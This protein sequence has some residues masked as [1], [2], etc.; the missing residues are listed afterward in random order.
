MSN[1]TALF[2][3]ERIPDTQILFSFT[4]QFIPDIIA[5]SNETNNSEQICAQ[6]ATKIKIYG[7]AQNEDGFK[8]KLLNT[9]EIFDKIEYSDKFHSLKKKDNINSIILSLSS[10]KICFIE[11]NMSYDTFE[12]LALYSVDKFFLGGKINIEQSFRICSSLSFGYIIFLF[13]ENKMSILRKKKDKKKKNL[14]V[15][16]SSKKEK[17]YSD[18]INGDKFFR[19][20]IYLN[21]LNIKYNIY[22]IINIYIPNKNFEL[23][24]FKNPDKKNKEGKIEIVQLYI[25]YVESKFDNND[26]INTNTTNT[27]D[28][29][30]MTDNKEVNFNNFM[31]E[32]L[33]LGLL[34]YNCKKNEYIDLQLIFSGVDENAFDFTIFEKENFNDN[35]AIVFSAYNIQLINF[36]SKKSTNYIL[37]P[38]YLSIFTTLYPDFNK[39]QINTNCID[40]K[41]DLRG[42]GFTVL[43]NNKFL[44]T[45]SN[46]KLYL[47]DLNE[48][49]E[50][51][52]LEIN[53]ANDEFCLC[54]PYNSILFVFEPLFFLS[55]PFADG[56]LL[57]IISGDTM[58][59]SDRIAN[60]SPIVNFHLVNDNNNNKKF[61]FTSGYGKNGYLSFAYDQFLCEEIQ[62]KRQQMN[63]MNDEINFMKTITDIDKKTKYLLCKSKEQLIIL[64]NNEKDILQPAQVKYNL[65][66]NIINFGQIMINKSN[67]KAI[68]LIY[69]KDLS[70]YDS[71]FN[72][73][74]NLSFFN[75]L[76]NTSIERVKFGENI[77]LIEN[78]NNKKYFLLGLFT[79][80]IESNISD[81]IEIEI[82]SGLYIR[83]RE[84][85]KFIISK[86]DQFIQASINSKLYLNKFNF[87]SVYLNNRTIKIYDITNALENDISPNQ[88][89]IKLLLFNEYI[90]YLP[91]LLINEK[92]NKNSLYA[93]ISNPSIDF[94]DSIINIF[95][96]NLS[97]SNLELNKNNSSN[98][99][100]L[101]HSMSFVNE[102]PDFVYFD[103]IGSL[104]IL[105]I[106]FKSGQLLM[107]TL[108]ISEISDDSKDIVS[109]GFKKQILEKLSD[110]DYKEI[111]RINIDK[112]F[113]PFQN[114]DN[115]SGILF[116]LKN[117]RKIFY[118]FNN[119]ICF[120]RIKNNIC[121]F[122]VFCQF[123]SE[124]IKNGFIIYETRYFKYF[125]LYKDF[126]FSNHSM[127][128]KTLKINRF[129][130]LLTYS[131]IY[132]M[133]NV[134]IYHFIMI[135]K[136][137][138]SPSEFQY[139]MTLR[140]SE[141]NPISEIKFKKNEVVTACE[142][143]ELEYNNIPKKF[144]VVGINIIDKDSSEYNYIKSKIEL[145]SMD[146]G[147]IA[148]FNEKKDLKGVIT[149]INFIK[150]NLNYY[151]FLIE[152]SYINIYKFQISNELILEPITH[153]ENKNL[154]IC[155][156]TMA[157]KLL[158]SGDICDSF[159][160]I[161]IRNNIS[162]NHGALLMCQP[163]HSL[164]LDI[165]SDKKDN[166]H[167]KVTSCGFWIVDNKQFCLLFDE[168]NNGYIY[169]LENMERVCDFCI[170]KNIT[171][172]KLVNSSN[173]NESIS[174]FYSSL[175]GSI[176]YIKKIDND[177]YEILNILCQFIYYHFPFNCGVNPKAF[178]N[179]KY[180]SDN[181]NNFQQPKG[182]YI[183][184]RVLDIFLKLSDK[185]QDF[186]CNNIL[187]TDKNVI[188][189]FIYDLTN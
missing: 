72:F 164:D 174:Y 150:F 124:E 3:Q 34:S 116:N 61:A 44:F 120:L 50:I 179:L 16:K 78:R 140:I 76:D 137:M 136:E 77:I 113:I 9:Y 32:K 39:Y 75:Y 185:F 151:L 73:I 142:V 64:E 10:F 40:K 157:K 13:D 66:S 30:N 110:I 183:D 86:E 152:G 103:S 12:T 37:N 155:N 14:E 15:E 173:V 125:N 49:N 46:G 132:Q 99:L 187:C 35:V 145:Y 122:N 55:S 135:E 96:S 21:D 52:Y 171:E 43:C 62:K 158:L 161:Y 85:G 27:N 154:G 117:N 83:I 8:L 48:K 129:P 22:K 28:D 181:K 131:P 166:N 89:R 178:Y 148:F 144:I 141:K 177:K 114:I 91:P 23:L 71:Y 123:N 93:S 138:I 134:V 184:F 81:I 19:P 6:Y 167:I 45:S 67:N 36:K 112:L 119:E 172:L 70:F 84:I 31:R 59:V 149:M 51:N 128:I 146:N 186:I 80:K 25:L 163:F 29:V 175:N 160:F 188:I 87:F 162:I 58:N 74:Y 57:N 38:N 5:S 189:K 11:Y 105:S 139:Y 60:Y 102:P 79:T 107:Y 133:Q 24:Y 104:C 180:E 42:N 65:N 153:F 1:L 4:G 94:S 53:I 170:N 106:I 95:S 88:N 127:M 101:N 176:G 165:I 169:S 121:S 182:R 130:V 118:E 68:V 82:N 41:I 63:E 56:I 69:E 143:V 2:H 92:I 111:C 147:K 156:I 7:I 109:I 126:H 159:N 54:S 17:S 18:T 97:S 108:Y 100:L 20:T 115:K 47:A 98:E 26:N 33:S 90:N 168:D